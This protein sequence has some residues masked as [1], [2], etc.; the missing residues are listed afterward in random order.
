MNQKTKLL[1]ALQQTNNIL[2]LLEDNEYKRF[3]YGHF[4]SAQVELERQ[5]TNLCRTDNLSK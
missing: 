5:L 3:L 2:D 1:L 4:I